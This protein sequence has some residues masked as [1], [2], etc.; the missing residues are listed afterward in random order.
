M[1]NP[2]RPNRAPRR[3]ARAAND[4]QRGGQNHSPSPESSRANAND[5]LPTDPLGRIESGDGIVED[6]DGADV[7][8]QSSVPH[9]LDYLTQLGTIG[10]DDEVDGQAVGGPRLWWPYDGYQGSSGPDQPCGP[11]LDVAADDVEHQVDAADVFQ[12]VVVEVDEV[13]RAEVERLL[14]VGGPPGADDVGASLTCE[15]HTHRPDCAGRTVREHALPR[16]KMA[17]VE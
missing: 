11:L 17:V 1:P 10:L 8:P 3:L 14:T 7:R 6:R 5:R 16:L 2:R 12:G 15:L 4:D 13:L 9:P